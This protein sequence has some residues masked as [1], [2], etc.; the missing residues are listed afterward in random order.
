MADAAGDRERKDGLEA[1]TWRNV[2]PNLVTIVI[3]ATGTKHACLA[4]RCTSSPPFL[5]S[6]N[7]SFRNLG[8]FI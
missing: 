3:E 5:Q 1:E 6:Y 2:A 7:G 4:Q 8:T